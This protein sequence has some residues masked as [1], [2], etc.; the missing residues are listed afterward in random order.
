MNRDDNGK[1]KWILKAV[2]CTAV[3]LAAF[4]GTRKGLSLLQEKRM[5]TKRTAVTA[6]EK[7]ENETAGETGEITVITGGGTGDFPD[8][9]GTPDKGGVSEI[10]QMEK[11]YL[12]AELSD[13]LKKDFAALYTAAAEF[14]NFCDLPVPVSKEDVNL[15]MTL[16]HTECPELFQNDSSQSYHMESVNDTVMTVTIPYSMGKTQ[17]DEELAGCRSAV[18]EI[19]AKAESGSSDYEKELTVYRELCSRLDYDRES[20]RA[21]DAAGVF[22]KGT[23]KCDGISLA[24]KWVMDELGI[25]CIVMAVENVEEGRDGHAWNLVKTDGIWCAV[26][27]TQD[28]DSDN[29]SILCYPVF[30]TSDTLLMKNYR[31]QAGFEKLNIPK[32]S[33]V[34]GSFHVRNGSY[35]RAGSEKEGFCQAM[36]RAAADGGMTPVQFETE[37][38]WKLFQENSAAWAEAWMEENGLFGTSSYLSVEAFRTAQIN[39]DVNENS[40]RMQEITDTLNTFENEMQTDREELT[41]LKK[42]LDGMLAQIE[43][44]RAQADGMRETDS[45]IWPD[46]WFEEYNVIAEQHDALQGTYRQEVEEYNRRVEEYRETL[47]TYNAL[48]KEYNALREDL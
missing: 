18:K 6:N 1:R 12:A 28:C 36:A 35:I 34:E 8:I 33:T 41:E 19:L 25:P 7:N 30:N 48:V 2:L 3:L 38:G 10:P 5:G 45:E 26:D 24:F 46:E 37:E 14:R 22:L 16:L 31:L 13:D 42:H 43:Q 23:G 11:K 17:Y 4:F 39:V 47:D 44:L 40:S 21:G 32:C 29:F 9:S 27:V 20:S 15:L